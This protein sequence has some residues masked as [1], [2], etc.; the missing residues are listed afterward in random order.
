[1]KINKGLHEG[2]P[3]LFGGI[4]F[5]KVIFLGRLN[6]ILSEHLSTAIESEKLVF[7]ITI[8]NIQLNKKG[9]Q[10]GAFFIIVTS[11]ISFLTSVRTTTLC[12]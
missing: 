12:T 4:I 6:T 9:H 3:Y 11:F 10:K 7:S 5:F 2:A 8:M 1:M